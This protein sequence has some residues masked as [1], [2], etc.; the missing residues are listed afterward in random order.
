MRRTRENNWQIVLFLVPAIAV[1]FGVHYMVKKS[2]TQ[3]VAV[4]TP[5]ETA[6]KALGYR[7]LASKDDEDSDSDESP[8]QDLSKETH[9]SPANTKTYSKK[10]LAELA[11]KDDNTCSSFELRGDGMSE[12]HVSNE[13]WAQ[14]MGLFHD[15]KSGLQSWIVAHNAEF[16]GGLVKWMSEQVDNARIQRPPLAEEPDLN[17]R[18]IGVATRAGTVA[19]SVP[20]IRV[21]GGFIK[22][23]QAEPKRARFELTR[24]IAQ[25]WNPCDMPT[26]AHAT[27]QP[28]LQCMGLKEQDWDYKKSCAVGSQTEAAWAMSTAV[29]AVVSPPGCEIPAFK[30]ASVGQCIKK[31]AWLAVPPRT[32]AVATSDAPAATAVSTTSRAPASVQEPATPTVLGFPA[33]PLEMT[34]DRFKTGAIKA[35]TLLEENR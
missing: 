31:T 17:W 34:T 10:E 4:A 14:V 23:V 13:E 28:L 25:A 5:T 8:E 20:L 7:A 29:A 1:G 15:S 27:W 32:A 22:M 11:G 30:T 21:G 6:D 16:P 33:S 12:T 24:L 26:G 9:R 3:V 2:K 18:G 35:P 19:D